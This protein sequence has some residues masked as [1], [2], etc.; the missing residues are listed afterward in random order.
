[1]SGIYN[2]PSPVVNYF[3]VLPCFTFN[4]SVFKDDKVK[5][6]LVRL[7]CC[8]DRLTAEQVL[9]ADCFLLPD[10][11]PVLPDDETT[12]FPNGDKTPTDFGGFDE[13]EN[14]TDPS[15]EN[16]GGVQI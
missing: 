6:L 3:F 15:M 11:I 16:R 14:E 5:S 10:V 1:M 8:N 2:L 13:Q 12:E 9:A 7:L 4:F